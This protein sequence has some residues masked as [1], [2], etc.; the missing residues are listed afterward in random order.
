MRTKMK[1]FSVALLMFLSAVLTAFTNVMPVEAAED[2]VVKLHYHREDGNYDGWDVWLWEVGFDGAAYAFAEE[3]G[4][5]VATKVIT[6]GVTSLGFIV[7]TQDW[8]KD[9]DEDQ[10]IDLTETEKIR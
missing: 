3:D 6:P 7:R 4:D 9:V 8:T 2:L 5:M 1:T 10:F